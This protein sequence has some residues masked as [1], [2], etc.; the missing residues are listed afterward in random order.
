MPRKVEALESTQLPLF[1]R[2]QPDIMLAPAVR[3]QLGTLIEALLLEVA[4]ALANK[5]AGDD[6]D[7]R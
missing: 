7:H 6:Q 4:A 1:E 5:E 3:Q 2:G